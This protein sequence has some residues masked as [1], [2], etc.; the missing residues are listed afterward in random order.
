MFVAVD[1][2]LCAQEVAMKWCQNK[3]GRVVIG[4][5]GASGGGAWLGSTGVGVN[6]THGRS[7]WGTMWLPS[8]ID[9]QVHLF[10]E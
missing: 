4:Y 8:S 10:I 7:C 9:N 3:S 1:Q 2:K 6:F 5:M